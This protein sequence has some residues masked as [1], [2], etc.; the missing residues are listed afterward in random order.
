M[1]AW[2]CHMAA[3]KLGLRHHVKDGLW[4]AWWMTASAAAPRVFTPA[5]YLY[6][7]GRKPEHLDTW[8]CT[9]IGGWPQR[10][11]Q[12]CT[13]AVHRFRHRCTAT[14]QHRR[15]ACSMHVCLEQVPAATRVPA[16]PPQP[17]SHGTSLYQ[18]QHQASE[19]VHMLC[20]TQAAA[21]PRVSGL[22]RCSICCARRVK[23]G[24]S[25]V[26]VVGTRKRDVKAIMSLLRAPCVEEGWG[27]RE[28][29]AWGARMWTQTWASW[30]RLAARA[31][32][33]AARVPAI[34]THARARTHAPTRN[35]NAKAQHY[36]LIRHRLACPHMHTH[37]HA[38]ARTHTCTYT[39]PKRTSTTLWLDMA[40]ARPPAHARPHARAWAHERCAPGPACWC[41]SATPSARATR[42]RRA[43]APGRWSSRRTGRSW[44]PQPRPA[45]ARHAQPGCGL[46]PHRLQMC[47]NTQPRTC[48]M[49]AHTYAL[50]VSFRT[51]Q[52]VSQQRP[53]AGCWMD[54][55]RP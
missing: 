28:R 20:R 39:Q 8:A 17:H 45:R 11:R 42:T 2:A 36:G 32:H 10:Q 43:Q 16:C 23:A 40:Q 53:P 34:H 31:A 18:V 6:E 7:A 21:Y 5:V 25:G 1:K 3:V 14:V 48:T 33:T 38:R 49:R 29:W 12:K 24:L 44:A 50:K 13:S 37:K 55:R 30:G 19:H 52:C 54:C 27:G 4:A 46:R 35:Q 9:Q 41:A 15:T 47:T 51:V 26:R 22:A